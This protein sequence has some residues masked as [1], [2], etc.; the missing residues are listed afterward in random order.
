MTN[1]D[2]DF[3]FHWN[4][5]NILQLTKIIIDKSNKNNDAIAKYNI[6]NKNDVNEVLCLLADDI[7][8]C[9]SLHTMCDFLLFI[10]SNNKNYKDILKAKS[11]LSHHECV[12]GSRKDIYDKLIIIK[13]NGNLAIEDIQF[14]DKLI[15]CYE[16]D[17]I[18]LNDNDKK[19]LHKVE[20]EIMNTKMLIN[21]NI[22]EY[23][24]IQ[25]KIPYDDLDGMPLHIINSFENI[26]ADNIKINL[27][28]TNHEL[29]LTYI[30]NINIRKLVDYNYS[31]NKNDVMEHIAKL[32]VLHDKHAKILGYNNHCEYIL[33]NKMCN[34]SDQI[35]LFLKKS[36]NK[37]NKLNNDINTKIWDHYYYTN[38]WKYENGYNDDLVKVYFEI[39]SVVDK[40]IKLYELLFSI[41]FIKL[42]NVDKWNNDLIVFSICDKNNNNLG[43]LYLDLYKRNG[44]INNT[45]CVCLQS[46]CMYP[47]S[48]NKYIKPIIVL[49]MSFDK[50]TNGKT[51]L[52]YD[53]VT[54]LFYE[55]GFVM[56]HIFGKTK[57][58]IFS[59]TNVEPDFVE[60]PAEMLKLLSYEPYIIKYMS[61]HYCKKDK[62]SDTLI[63]KIIQLKNLKNNL[64]YKKNIIMASM[65]Q[66][67]YSSASFVKFCETSLFENSK[68]I[69]E[70]GFKML[71][72]QLFKEIV[73]K[74]NKNMYLPYDFCQII[75]NFDTQ[76]Y[77][78]LWSKMIAIDIFNVNIKNKEINANIGTRIIDCIYK[79]GG[80]KSGIDMYAL[81]RGNVIVLNDE[82]IIIN[83]TIKNNK[84]KKTNKIE[85]IKKIKKNKNNDNVVDSASNYFCEIVDE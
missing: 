44:K 75:T 20:K 36:L 83:K 22:N 51:L 14:V 2:N 9:E 73:G 67:I 46:A 21:D 11:L 84:H 10:D 50:F 38:L 68:D 45:R 52:T 79:Y 37:I 70:P 65:D 7:T 81:Y 25:I 13:N 12:V 48:L 24:N 55:F 66:I 34:K 35:Q 16:K 41:K 32:I 63:N 17:G 26:D 80:T 29:C 33:E 19:V 62:M 43:Y 27:N 15:N 82:N 57:Y 71:Y 58:V 6:I 54:E 74:C 40:L 85:K 5:T 42:N 3:I 18:K 78:I 49:C 56:H 77:N 23:E 59:G 61:E 60:I 47:L 1:I 76:Y 8:I 64:G 4:N 31:L 72:K 69:I 39:N 53:D 30:K 28:K